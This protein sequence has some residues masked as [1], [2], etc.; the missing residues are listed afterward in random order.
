[1][2]DN[3]QVVSDPVKDS[4]VQVIHDRHGQNDVPLM[5]EPNPPKEAALVLWW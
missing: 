3:G 4:G 5:A 1:M 2:A